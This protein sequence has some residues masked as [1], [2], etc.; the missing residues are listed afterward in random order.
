MSE[1]D[2]AAG[3]ARDRQKAATRDQIL[4]AV[5]ARLEAGPLAD[6]PL[7]ARAQPAGLGARAG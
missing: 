2:N 7:A 5:G 1:D 4:R 6:L 3:D